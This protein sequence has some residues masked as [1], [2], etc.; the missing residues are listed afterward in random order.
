MLEWI[1]PAL[2]SLAV[3]LMI[4]LSVLRARDAAGAGEDA[5]QDLAL[6]RKQLDD[7]AR[8]RAR[9]TIPEDEAE[10]LRAEIARRLI[11]ADTRAARARPEREP[12]RLRPALVAFLLAAL[13]ALPLGLYARI[14]A[15]GYGDLALGDRLDM[16]RERREGRPDQR[17]AEAEVPPIAVP[18]QEDAPADFETLIEKLR[19]AVLERPDDLEGQQLLARNEAALGNFR[20]AYK[21]QEE[22][23][24]LKGDEATAA[25]FIAYADMLILAAGGYVSPEAEEALR[26][27]LARDPENGPARYYMGLMMRQN[28]RPDV[29]FRLWDRLLR[30][31][32]EDAAW[33]P[34]IRAQIDRAAQLAGIDYDQ[35]APADTLAG[36]S[37]E[38]IADAAN[39]SEA[40]RAE[41]VRGMVSRLSDRLA[42]QGGSPEEWA[43]LIRAYGVLGDTA[44]A[45]AIAAEARQVFAAVPEAIDRIAA[46]EASLSED[47][48][49]DTAESAEG[50]EAGEDAEEPV[51]R[52]PARD[53]DE[54]PDR[55]TETSPPAIPPSAPGPEQMI[56]DDATPEV[57]Q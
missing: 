20:A 39:L 36:P 51:E 5:G 7:V 2:M 23:L 42:T 43:R 40:A 33:I 26:A 17:T 35:P 27:A 25:D 14:G 16:A 52:D 49:E 54:A 50:G 53:P 12:L 9:G 11:A 10:R 30:D 21:A 34:P 18:Q 45:R 29:A 47:T 38:D 31:G 55:A 48:A 13:V 28:D 4:G 24:S 3:A 6:Y 46:A 15:P 1:I 41:M 22:V 44:R 32:P 56:G 37:A 19:L 8:D 57:S